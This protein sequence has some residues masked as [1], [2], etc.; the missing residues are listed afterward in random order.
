MPRVI[1]EAEDATSM[2]R[3]PYP[4]MARPRRRALTTSMTH[5]QRRLHC[6]GRASGRSSI[7]V[8]NKWRAKINRKRLYN[9]RNPLEERKDLRI[10]GENIV[11]IR[12][13]IVI[14]SRENIFK[15]YFPWILPRKD[16][17]A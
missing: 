10:N 15:N 5:Y 16:F 3:R 12:I 17:F 13:G 8:I 2:P 14:K 6:R 4:R 1:Y 7:Y 9:V 11:A